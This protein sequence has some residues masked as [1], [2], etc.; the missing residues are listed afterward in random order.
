MATHTMH[1]STIGHIEH[2]GVFGAIEGVAQR[3]VA[4]FRVAAEARRARR[5][6]AQ[7]LECAMRD[8]A[9]MAELRAISC[10]DR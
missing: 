3:I 4:A 8:P 5:E 1:R 2:D 9:L 6:D 7:M 10:R